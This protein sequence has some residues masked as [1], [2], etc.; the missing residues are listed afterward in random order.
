M[1][2]MESK[3]LNALYLAIIQITLFR[4]FQL[5]YHPHICKQPT[6]TPAQVHNTVPYILTATF[7]NL[8]CGTLPSML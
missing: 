6:P 2:Y 1:K 5:N 4:L 8:S 7:H 3:S